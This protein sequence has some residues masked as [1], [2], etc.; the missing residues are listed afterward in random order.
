MR[1][2]N[3]IW[4]VPLFN[5]VNQGWRYSTNKPSGKLGQTEFTGDTFWKWL[6]F[7][8]VYWIK[9]FTYCCFVHIETTDWNSSENVTQQC[10]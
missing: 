2:L 6:L 4:E 9:M 1:E 8:D 10:K 3:W 7:L 5:P